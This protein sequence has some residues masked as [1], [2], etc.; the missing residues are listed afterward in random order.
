MTQGD[1]RRTLQ[2]EG[3]G[4]GGRHCHL[5]VARWGRAAGLCA[6]GWS[7]GEVGGRKESEVQSRRPG[8]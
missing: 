3:E 2:L 1:F 6:G 5:A 4:V 7:E 8:L